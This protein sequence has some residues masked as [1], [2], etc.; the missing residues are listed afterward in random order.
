VEGFNGYVV[1][2]LYLAIALLQV[3]LQLRVLE[4]LKPLDEHAA[5]RDHHF[6]DFP[7]IQENER[8]IVLTCLLQ[9]RLD[10]YVLDFVLPD[11][12]LELH[13]GHHAV[14]P[15]ILLDVLVDHISDQ[16]CGDQDLYPEIAR[17]EGFWVEV[18]P[19]LVVS[20]LGGLLLLFVVLVVAALLV[21]KVVDLSFWSRQVGC[22]GLGLGFAEGTE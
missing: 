14:E 8:L 6:L 12:N 22:F 13:V 21:S 15:E 20:L 1:D 3:H 5:V 10:R 2:H 4:H 7:R 9:H 19:G 17:L 18:K 16:S 11:R